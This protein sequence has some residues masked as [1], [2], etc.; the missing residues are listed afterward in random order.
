MSYLATESLLC[1]QTQYGKHFNGNYNFNQH[2]EQPTG[3][4]Q[5]DENVDWEAL[6]STSSK[7]VIQELE[8]ALSVE[9][10]VHFAPPKIHNPSGQKKRKI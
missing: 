1:L 5:E 6:Q 9:W 2:L 3:N 10:K 8:N 7:D 4:D